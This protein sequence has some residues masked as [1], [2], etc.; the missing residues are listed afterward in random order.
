MLKKLVVALVVVTLT[1]VALCIAGAVVAPRF[2]WHVTVVSGGSMQPAIAT[3]SVA[4]GQPVDVHDIAVGDAILFAPPS[5]PATVTIHRVVEV[6]AQGGTLQFRTQ[7]DA[8]D[9]PDPYVV[10]A[11]NVKG[12]VRLTVPYLGYALSGIGTPVGRSLLFGV[13][14][15]LLIAHELHR[16]GAELRARRARRR[17][18]PVRAARALVKTTDGGTTPTPRSRP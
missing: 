14:A 2:G 11:Q 18:R 9:A 15:L 8:N 13:P 3:G 12:R 5:A 1:A 10:P 6:F 17:R 7:G 16:I 4:V